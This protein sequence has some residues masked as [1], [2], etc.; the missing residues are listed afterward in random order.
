MLPRAFEFCK[1]NFIDRRSKVDLAR[2]PAEWWGFCRW[3]L[4]GFGLVEIVAPNDYEVLSLSC[5]YGELVVRKG[6]DQLC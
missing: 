5:G 4:A 1:R 3:L 2:F 6:F